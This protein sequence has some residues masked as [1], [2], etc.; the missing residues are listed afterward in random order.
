MFYSLHSYWDTAA[1]NR[2]TTTRPIPSTSSNRSAGY[3]AAAQSHPTNTCTPSCTLPISTFAQGCTEPTTYWKIAHRRPSETPNADS[4]S[5]KLSPSMIEG[6]CH[7]GCVAFTLAQAPESLV[8]CNCSICRRIGALWGHLEI[9]DVAISLVDGKT[10]AYTHG[11]QELAFHT[12]A[13][14]GCTTLWEN[15]RP[16]E[17]T[18]MAANFR[19]CT[20]DVIG[21]FE[22]RKFD[23]ADTWQFLD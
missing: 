20:P 16:Q 5:P 2:P 4:R 6:S 22:I 10:I 19:M 17:Y 3:T 8:D 13:R 21:Q 14:C 1:A 7:C 23:G 11:D 12:C 9:E 18:H 15:L